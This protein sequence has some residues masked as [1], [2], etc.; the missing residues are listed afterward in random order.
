M[1]EK[2]R[3]LDSKSAGPLMNLGSVCIQAKDYPA[4]RK[5]FEEAIKL[6]P[7]GRFVSEAKQ[8]LAKLKKK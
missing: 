1:F 3:Q 6:E 8:A 4:A 7:N 2:A 5:Y